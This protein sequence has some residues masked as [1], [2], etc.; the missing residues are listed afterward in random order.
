MFACLNEST[1]RVYSHFLPTRT[2]LL[3]VVVA[4]VE[5]KR[6]QV[7][8]SEWRQDGDGVTR[9]STTKSAAGREGLLGHT[10]TEPGEL[11]TEVTNTKHPARNTH[12]H[13][14]SRTHTCTYTYTHTHT[15]THTHTYTHTYRNGG[16]DRSPILLHSCN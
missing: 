8:H 10:H 7:S 14:H 13:T 12:T 11:K 2:Q 15:H 3:P 9:V 1:H 4:K 16:S 6:Q 5:V